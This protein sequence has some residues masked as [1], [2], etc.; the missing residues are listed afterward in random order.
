[1]VVTKSLEESTY[2]SEVPGVTF[3]NF[4]GS[5]VKRNCDPTGH[6]QL[7][8]RWP[9]PVFLNLRETAAR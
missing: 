6:P 2:Y 8:V 7:L 9:T 1:M 4:F 3:R 5:E